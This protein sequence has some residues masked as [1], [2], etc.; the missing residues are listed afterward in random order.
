MSDN[1]S[2]EALNKAH[3]AMEEYAKNLQEGFG[4]DSVVIIVTRTNKT[5]SAM[6]STNAGSYHATIG[7]IHEFMLRQNQYMMPK[8]E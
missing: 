7:A 1:L 5:E 8:G 2:S 3:A 6:M 4:F